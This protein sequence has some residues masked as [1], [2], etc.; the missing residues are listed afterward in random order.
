[1]AKRPENRKEVPAS[2][3]AP[4]PIMM[5]SKAIEN[6]RRRKEDKKHQKSQEDMGMFEDAGGR[7]SVPRARAKQFGNVQD[8]PDRMAKG[9]RVTRGDGACVKG[10]T[11]GRYI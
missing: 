7:G 6:R 3:L 8:H 9:G 11:K 4:S 1:M 10:K 2:D 5:I